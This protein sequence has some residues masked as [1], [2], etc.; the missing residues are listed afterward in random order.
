[1]NFLDISINNGR[2]CIGFDADDLVKAIHN[3]LY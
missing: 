1:M 2:I 3:G